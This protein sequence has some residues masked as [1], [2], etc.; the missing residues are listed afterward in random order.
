M[1][2]LCLSSSSQ[3]LFVSAFVSF[4]KLGKW[5]FCN[6]LLLHTKDSI[7]LYICVVNDYFW[8]SLVFI[9]QKAITLKL[10]V[11]NC[12]VCFWSI[13]FF[14]FYYRVWC[15]HG[16]ACMCH[17]MCVEVEGHLY[18][19]SS[20]LLEYGFQKLDS[21]FRS[22]NTCYYSELFHQ[23]SHVFW[24]NFYMWLE[25]GFQLHSLACEFQAF[26]ALLKTFIC[27]SW[28]SFDLAFKSLFQTFHRPICLSLVPCFQLM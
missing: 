2:V 14:K 3:S 17:S 23:P 13:L 5:V 15:V 9:C 11:M 1:T 10:V 6:F 22:Q 18:E 12:C 8:A 27:P 21:W 19:I 16:G 24:G 7:P 28:K 4:V 25:V 26:L 20:L